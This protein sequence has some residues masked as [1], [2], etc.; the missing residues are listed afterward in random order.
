MAREQPDRSKLGQ[1][2]ADRMEMFDAGY[3]PTWNEEMKLLAEKHCFTD[4]VLNLIWRLYEDL[5][6][7]DWNY[8]PVSSIL[9]VSILL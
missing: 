6:S 5:S 7:R 3:Q 2:H 8:L 1:G 4:A 9:W